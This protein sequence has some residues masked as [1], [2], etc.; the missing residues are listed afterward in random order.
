MALLMLAPLVFVPSAT[1]VEGRSSSE[2][3]CCPA[4]DLELFMLGSADNGALSPFSERL[5]DDPE[6][7]VI[8][9]AVTS[10]EVVAT[11]RL[12]DLYAGTVP[13]STWSIRLPVLVENAGGAQVNFSVEVAIGSNVFVGELPAPSTFVGQ[14]SSTV[15][16]DVQVDETTV[17]DGWDL[18]V[19]LLARSVIFSV[20]QSGSQLSVQ[21]GAED[22]DA[23]I[24]GELSAVEM[25]LLDVETDGADAYIG[26]V[27][28]SPFGTDL[29]AFSNDL[30]L[31]LDG[32]AISGDPVETQSADGIRV[33]WTYTDDEPGERTMNLE[34]TLR[35]QSG[36]ATITSETTQVTFVTE[37]GEGGGGTYYPSEEPLRT[38]GAGSSLSIVGTLDVSQDR[39]ELVFERETSITLDGEMSFWMRWSLDHL[40]S[41]DLALSPTIRSFR[42]G[43][44]G[45]EERESRMIESVERQE[46]EQQMGK[47]HVSFLSNG[48]GLKPDEL[49][50][51]SGDFDTVGVAL[52]L[53]GEERVIS[54]PVTITI[55][56]RER[57]ADGTL[58]DLVRDF[59]VVQPVPFWSEWSIDLTLRT[60]G[61]TSLAG[62]DLGDADGLSLNHRRMPMGEVAVLS[63]EDL[64]QGLTFELI[65][66]P[67]SAPLYAPLV[68]LLGTMAVLI[69]GIALGWRVSRQRRRALLMTEVVL[70]SIIVLAIFLFAY[71]SVFVLG[72]AG[73]SAFIW[74]VTA[75]VSPR[76][77]RPVPSGAAARA[78]R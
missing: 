36:G 14:G 52:D 33:T 10:E 47:L 48:L 19:V 5:G 69:G 6:S 73:S 16:F 58:I 60:S 59:I 9:N 4:V 30:T 7:A 20:P 71:P 8:A 25:S 38:T 66:A 55:R 45:D 76:T 11:W 54:H 35:L 15:S 75:L 74:S 42:A 64:D 49:I 26:V 77:S 61:L 70:L 57:V 23:S 46:F 27:L 24:S 31:R 17:G 13:D 1:A 18:E 72:A 21:W 44:V 62:L 65:A 39:G 43:G 12:Q 34:V 63:G 50:G 41:E 22:A 67:T 37:G 68:V 2:V 78:A 56:S 29:L 3:I 40:G 32:N 51:D 53:H 28:A